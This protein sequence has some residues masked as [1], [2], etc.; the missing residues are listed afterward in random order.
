M[1]LVD[2]HTHSNR[3]DGTLSPAQV[4]HAAA[5]R[6]VELFALA[7]HDTV[8]GCEAARKAAEGLKLPF[9]NAVEVSTNEDDHLHILAYG[10]NPA[11]KTF[12]SFLD[13]MR[14]RRV[15]RIVSIVRGLKE[16]GVGLDENDVAHEAAGVRGRAHVA[17]AL[18]TRG[19][20]TTRQDAF[21]KFLVP[22]KPGYRPPVGA[23]AAQALSAIRAAGGI[24][25]LA[26]PGVVRDKW[27]FPE[28]VSAGLGG[29]EAYYPSHSVEITRELL[30]IASR[31]GLVATA[32]S[33]YHGPK[34]G[35]SKTLGLRIPDEDYEILRRR[36]LN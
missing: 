21:R 33:D 35:I 12:V 19:F 5:E 34:T 36:L 1:R 26:H 23:S 25:V 14:A 29:V 13:Q 9:V 17:D 30:A 32:G 11:D 6:K 2:L 31:Y 15:E 16:S 27:N 8:D 28:W 4:A 7:D 24:P 22:G 18:V 10:I 20:A 3:S